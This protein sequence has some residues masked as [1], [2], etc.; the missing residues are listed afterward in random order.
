MDWGFLFFSFFFVGTLAGCFEM[1]IV[2]YT[3]IRRTG[4]YVAG[5]IRR[6]EL[7]RRL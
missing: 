1:K 3:Y 6:R 5:F 2:G 7:V 4:P